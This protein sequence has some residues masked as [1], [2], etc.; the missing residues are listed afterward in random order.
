MAGW[1]DG[2]ADIPP[3]IHDYPPFREELLVQ[4]HVIFKGY[5]MV[6]P[7]GRREEI[8]RKLHASHLGVQ[9]CLRRAYKAL[10]CP[11]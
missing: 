1:Q 5:R 4:E 7:F 11:E 9:A 3:A 8:N 2:K 10:F 6:I